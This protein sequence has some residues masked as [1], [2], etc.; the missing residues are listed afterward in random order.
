MRAGGL[1]RR[2]GQ[3][4]ARGSLVPLDRELAR[5]GN[6]E[7]LVDAR[8]EPRRV[9]DRGSVV[10]GNLFSDVRCSLAGHLL[11]PAGEPGVE[12]RAF[13]TGEAAVAGIS[14]EGV[15]VTEGRPGN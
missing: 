12:S 5:A 3:R 7:T 13:G 9:G 8:T 11:V 1:M 15:P 10:G 4:L 2:I 6:V 14:Q